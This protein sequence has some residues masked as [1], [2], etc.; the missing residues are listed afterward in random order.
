MCPQGIAS[1]WHP[2]AIRRAGPRVLQDAENDMS[3]TKPY[4]GSCH[5]GKARLAMTVEITRAS[6]C[7]CSLCGQ[8]GW[9]MVSAGGQKKRVVNVRGAEDGEE[10][11]GVD[12][13]EVENFDGRSY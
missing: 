11:L 12:A 8:L 6:A 5:C 3:E 4:S 13:L 9:L 2:V 10:D 7:N 1:T